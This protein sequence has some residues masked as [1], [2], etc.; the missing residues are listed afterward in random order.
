MER[1]GEDVEVLARVDESPVLCRH[2][3][4]VVAAFH[5]E[6]SNDDRI[7]GCFLDWAFAA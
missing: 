5:P 1:I 7:H 2:G 4:V 3:T 6:M